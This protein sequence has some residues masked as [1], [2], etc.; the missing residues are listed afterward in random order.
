MPQTILITG[1]AGFIGSHLTDALL[2][3]GRRV[4]LLDDLSGHAGSTWPA[5]LDPRAERMRGDVR[6]ASAV[7]AALEGV[8]AV[9]HLAARSGVGH[10]LRRMDEHVSTNVYGTAVLLEALADRPAARLVVASSTS[11]Y[12]EGLYATLEGW[13]RADVARE[14]DALRDGEWDPRDDAGRQLRP[15]PTPE[16]KRIDLASVHALTKH[17]QERLCLLASEACGMP[18]VALRLSNVY[19]PRQVLSGPGAGVLAVFAARLLA[20]KPPI[21]FE[22]GEQRRDFVSVHDVVQAFGL[23]LETPISGVAL[24]VGSGRAVSVRELARRLASA[25]GRRD[26]QPELVEEHRDGDVRHCLPS[27]AR[28]RRLLGYEPRVTLED[29]LAELAGWLR[30]RAADARVGT[31]G[32]APRGLAI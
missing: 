20:G 3:R 13:P 2:A 14:H 19:G 5:H 32:L 7:R 22:D 23:A 9:V 27:I 6:D 28:V 26:I 8:D 17:D 1:G 18:A 29:G 30:G 16:D 12:G 11:I 24:N 31:H 10:S 15:L 25:M 21:L 4:R